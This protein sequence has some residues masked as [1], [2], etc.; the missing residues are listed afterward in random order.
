MDEIGLPGGRTTRGVV[1]IGAAIRRPR[2]LTTPFVVSLLRHLER[3]GFDA[4][5]RF[6]GVDESERII[7]S[8]IEGDVPEDIGWHQDAV[9]TEAA[10]LIRR[11]HDATA[12]LMD[13][14]AA[15]SANLE[16]VCHND[17]SPCNAVFRD[18]LPAALIDF[19]AAAPGTRLHDL[20]YAAWLWLDLGNEDIDVETQRRRLRLFTQAYGFGGNDAQV[21]DAALVRQQ[22]LVEEGRRLGNRQMA[23]WAADCRKWTLESLP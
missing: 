4:A 13:S 16:V 15:R 7:L 23:Q 1:R 2:R 21:V 20:G 6:L 3:A 5:P 11:Y 8:F 9:L 10:R 17:L 18:G 22:I 19:D 14:P 12:A